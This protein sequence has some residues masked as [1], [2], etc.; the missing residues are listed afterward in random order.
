MT[1][2]R[3]ISQPSVRAPDPVGVLTTRWTSPRSIQ[4]STCGEPSPILLRGLDGHSHPRDGLGGAPCGDDPKAVVVEDLGDGEGAVLVGVGDG[5]E[6]GA[7][8]G[9]GHAGGGLGLGEGGGEVAGDTHDLAGG[10]HLGAEHGVGSVEAVEG[11]HGL[12]DGDVLAVAH[13]L[14]ALGQ[15]ELSDPLAE[16]DAAGEPG[17]RQAD[18]L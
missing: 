3:R 13:A 15:A 5:D 8:G 12:L 7:L 18:G 11:Q 17:E 14:P 2:A 1:A 10:A 9:K 4:S 6:G 16:H